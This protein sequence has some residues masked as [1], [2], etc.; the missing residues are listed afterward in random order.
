MDK[1][2][3]LKLLV[4]IF[5]ATFL[6][7]N[8]YNYVQ[9]KEATIN[10]GYLPS[11][12]HAAV[13]V[14]DELNMYTK[15]GLNVNLVPFRSGKE[16]IAALEKGQI[17]I[18]YCGIAPATAA[19]SEGAPV[20][21]VA[22]V[23]TGGSGVVGELNSSSNLS[24]DLTGK[25]VA[26]PS[27]GSVQDVILHDL[28]ADNNISTSEINTI[29]LESP[30]MPESLR[31]GKINAYVAWEP[32]VTAAKVNGYGRVLM[33]SDDWWNNHP[34]CVVVASYKFIENNPSELSRFLKAHVK[35]TTFIINNKEEASQIVAQKLG[36]SEVLEA[37]SLNHLNYTCCPN[38][39]F[40]QNV[41][42]FM[43]IQMRLGYLSQFP[44]ND[45]LYDFEFLSM[46]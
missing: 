21:I 18:G 9:V 35:A 3:I 16:V 4:I 5:I 1:Y 17:D 2:N 39:N 6:V 43:E 26:I 28:L 12:H 44:S 24:E 20:K 40:T 31:N 13:F 45:S 36:S 22:P 29:E 32:Y 38:Q 23:N 19:I 42:Q 27:K 11:N 14:A 7:Y 46:P 34:C 30:L 37:E 25:T 41:Y 10:V 8:T 33:Y 15:A